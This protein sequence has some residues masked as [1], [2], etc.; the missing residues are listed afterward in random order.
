ME[1]LSLAEIFDAEAVE[2]SLLAACG[3]SSPNIQLEKQT[4]S[5]DR[6]A[7]YLCKSESS[8]LWADA[9]CLI[10]FISI[11]KYFIDFT[12]LLGQNGCLKGENILSGDLNLTL[13]V[14]CSL[15]L[16]L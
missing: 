9:L 1:F 7:C 11:S 16:W 8:V 6:D 14:L 13:E 10:F 3:E 2:A 12:Q 15:T 5:V 4:K